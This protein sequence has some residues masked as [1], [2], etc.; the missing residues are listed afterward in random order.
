MTRQKTRTT[1]IFVSPVACG[2]AALWR[3]GSESLDLQFS[4]DSSMPVAEVSA[5]TRKCQH[6][7]QHGTHRW[8]HPKYNIE[9]TSLARYIVANLMMQHQTA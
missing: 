2:G 5:P 1:N 9:R 8:T 3:E 7:A 4:V 6:E